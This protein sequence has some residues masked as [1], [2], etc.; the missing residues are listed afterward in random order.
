M[1]PTMLVT[2]VHGW[3][4]HVGAAFLMALVLATGVWWTLVLRRAGRA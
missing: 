1:D 2:T 4:A 3:L